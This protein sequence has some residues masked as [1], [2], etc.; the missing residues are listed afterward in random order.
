[1]YSRRFARALASAV[2]ALAA[3]GAS[4]QVCCDVVPLRITEVN[5]NP[6]VSN[7]FEFVELQNIGPS[8]LNIGGFALDGVTFSFPTNTMLAA[9]ERVV[10]SSGLAPLSYF[11]QRYPGVPVAGQFTGSLD[12][13]GERLGLRDASGRNITAVHYRDGG[14]WPQAADGLGLTLE[15]IDPA[16]DPDDPANWRASAVTNGTP[17]DASPP[18]PAPT[19]LFHEV[20][21]E[22]ATVT[23]GTNYPD[24]VE[25]FNPG[26]TNVDLAGW[27]FSDDGNERKFVFPPTNL[28]PGGFLIVWCD[29]DT[30]APGLHSG[31]VLNKT[32]ESLALYDAATNRI[33]AFTFGLQAQDKSVGLVGG[34]WQL[35]APTPGGANAAALT[36][37]PTNLVINEW[38]V[39][40]TPGKDDW[41]E[42]LNR[43]TNHP[44]ALRGL[45]FATTNAL[46]Q[47]RALSFLEPGQFLQIQCDENAGPDH[48]EFKLPN[49][50]GAVA[51]FDA[52]GALIDQVTYGTL[53][54]GV[55]QG[56]YPDGSANIVTFTNSAS[57][58]T[59]NFFL[60]YAGP[61]LN[62]FM[63]RNVASPVVDSQ[64]RRA[65]WLELYNPLGVAFDLGGMSLSEGSRDRG[66]WYFPTGTVIAAQGYLI[67]W[68]D[69][70]RAESTNAEPDLNLGR[71]LNGD[72]G[73]LFLFNAAGQLVDSTLYG[74]QARDRSVGRF[75]GPWGMLAAATPGAT[76]AAPLALGSPLTLKINEW[77]AFPIEGDD[78][79]E[80]Y[81]PDPLPVLL[82]GLFLADDPSPFGVTNTLVEP[83]TFI[84][85]GG[86]VRFH[87][88]DSPSRGADHVRFSLLSAG[89]SI[90]LSLS[91]TQV[92]DRVDFTAQTQG[93]SEGRLPNGST[94]VTT[95]PFTP[96]PGASNTLPVAPTF[97]LHPQSQ[98]VVQHGAVTFSVM[99]TGFPNVLSYQWRTFGTNIPGATNA[100]LTLSNVQPASAGLYG[101]RVSNAGGPRN[102]NNAQLAVL[103]DTDADGMPDAWEMDF[104]FDKTN[105]LDA[106]L[107]ADEDGF[108][109]LHEF[110]AGTSPTNAASALR[111]EL[112]PVTPDGAVLTFLAVSNRSY[113]AEWRG[114][115]TNTPW[116]PWTNLPAAPTNRQVT[117]T[118]APPAP[119][120]R[121]FRLGIP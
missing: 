41:F 32:G 100:T 7:A 60:D 6:T 86:F 91:P 8:N 62:E 29:N 16:G 33:D 89:E 35:T 58:G 19:V 112:L 27:S 23:F 99:A 25:F 13:N 121:Y 74:P 54:P 79:F 72:S 50:G 48:A 10:V 53:G 101:C 64:G 22:N 51:V 47:A 34:V 93:Q 117:L 57:P 63:A 113:T 110:L 83:L 70:A 68:C 65:D 12:N 14:G 11:A 114:E 66:E 39:N 61:L 30:N 78:W 106:V 119:A 87:A 107:D 77:M 81:N 73:G 120:Q 59:T 92:I 102:S 67:L 118:N 17:M 18:L 43:D 56:R 111:L 9:G 95:F 15:V 42:L 82:S 75:D 1:M 80:L 36:A 85:G 2:L 105:S 52:A 116:L 84:E 103:P 21:A 26:A 90:V 31:F 94:N 69:G 28:P 24:W 96:T 20:M 88:D 55:S 5:Y 45:Y 71:A 38:L 76:N 97:L 40:P 49:V 98:S 109:N 115:F 44:V 3:L 104:G 46:F 37:S 4:A 108:I